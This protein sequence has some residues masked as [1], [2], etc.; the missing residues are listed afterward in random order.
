MSRHRHRNLDRGISQPLAERT[1]RARASRHG[2]PVTKRVRRLVEKDGKVTVLFETVP[3]MGEQKVKVAAGPTG[4]YGKPN[5]GGDNAG[6]KAVKV[7]K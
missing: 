4:K 6:K 2:K 5:T 3:V 1:L 7:E